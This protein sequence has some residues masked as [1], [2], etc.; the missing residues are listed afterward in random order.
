[1]AASQITPIDYEGF[2]DSIRIL[3]KGDPRY[4]DFD[5]EGSGLVSIIRLLSTVSSTQG[6]NSH[7]TLAESHVSTSEILENVQALVTATSGFYVPNGNRAA[8]LTADVTITPPEPLSAPSS[9]TIPIT[10]SSMGVSEGRTFTFSPVVPVDVNLVSGVYTAVVEMLEGTLVTNSF[11]KN[12]TGLET[13]EIPNKDIDVSTIR[14]FI[15]TSSSDT[16]T[17]EFDKFE[18]AFQLGK[19]NNLFYLSMNRRGFYQVEFGDGALS[20][21][22]ADG[23]IIY[24]RG[25]T[26]SGEAANGVSS[27]VPTSDIEAFSG[28]TIAVQSPA[29]GG[30]APEDIDSI[31]RRSA[32]S[33]GMDGVVVAT[34]EYGEKLSNFLPNRKIT[35]WGGENNI[36]PKPGY[37]I[38]CVSPTLTDLEKLNSNLYLKKYNVGSIFT[39]IVD[40]ASYFIGLKIY[41]G[42]TSTVD[43]VKTRLSQEIRIAVAKYAESKNDFSIEFEP[44]DL[45]DYIKNNVSNLDRV[46][47]TYNLGVNPTQS[48]SS[49]NFNFHRE[50]EAGTFV[51]TF[52]GHP[53]ISQIKDN[54][55][56]IFSSY[57][58]GDLVEQIVSTVDYVNGVV[59]LQDL[60]LTVGIVGVG[61][62][63]AGGVDLQLQTQRNEILSIS[64]TS[65]DVE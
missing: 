36:P 41:A 62:C 53:T 22:L 6:L 64:I 25:V 49:L 9:I 50:I 28:I 55:E 44:S 17:V 13:F 16:T 18:S 30:S 1:M 43:S 8:K 52:S 47:I 3:M 59:T 56:G 37:V 46:Y 5:F 65:L 61:T 57:F 11:T 58:D 24:V 20:K 42:C 40:S 63:D 51:T 7:L 35:Q 60:D 2:K 14:V 33:F 39:E 23:N 29:Q 32:V 21:A 4:K 45:E 34:Q 15:R 19:D 48:K 12:G 31:K 38:L 26:N 10:F 54:A 27:L